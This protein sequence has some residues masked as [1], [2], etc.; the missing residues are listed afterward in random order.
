MAVVHAVIG[1]KDALQAIEDEKVGFAVQMLE[2]QAFSVL[3]RHVANVDA[4]T[5]G[6]STLPLEEVQTIGK[7]Q[8]GPAS[9]LAGVVGF[10]PTNPG[11]RIRCLRPLG[12]TPIV[13]MM[14]R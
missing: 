10:E 7:S 2:Q 8:R 9:G 4:C 13:M 3:P 11:I 1:E 6:Q 5:G 14:D 12:Y